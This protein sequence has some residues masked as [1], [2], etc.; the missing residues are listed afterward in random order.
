VRISV[1]AVAFCVLA[2]AGCRDD[3]KKPVPSACRQGPD[4]V[5]AALA[6]APGQVRLDGTTR[7]S[8]C[9]KETSTGGEMSDVGAAYIT[10]AQDLADAGEALRLGY[11]IGAVERSRKGSQGVGYELGR[12]LAQEASRVD[13][14]SAAY[15]EGLRAGRKSG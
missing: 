9:I 3:T 14:R 5:S 13:Q 1:A 6:K 10:V 8:A 12:R 11:L 2:L 7:I 4:T 15:R